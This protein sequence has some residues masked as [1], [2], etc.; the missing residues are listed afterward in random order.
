[1][2]TNRRTFLANGAAL[3][4][5]LSLPRRVLGARSPLERV[6]LGIVG[7]GWRGG[8]LLDTFKKIDGV[9]I[10]GLCDPD[11]KR[12]GAMA[13][14]LT[15]RPP[16]WKDMRGLFD[17]PDIDAVV[18]ANPN[19]WH[20]LSAIWALQ[21]GK[22]V[23]V[24]KPLGQ[25]QWEAQQLVNAVDR[26]GRICQV[27]T[28]QR[29]DPIQQEIRQLLHTDRA[30]GAIQSVTINRL[31]ERKPIGRRTSPMDVPPTIDFDLWTGPAQL[32]PI[33]R[34]ELQYDWH[35]DWNTG[36]GEMGNW[37]VHVLDDVRGTVLLDR[38]DLPEKVAATGGRYAWDDAGDTPNLQFVLFQAGGI[39]VQMAV[40]N[41]PKQ[42]G[43]AAVAGPPTG[44]TV[45]CE[46]GRLEGERG[47]AVAFDAQGKEVRR[48]AG[49]SGDVVHQK[50][51]IDA[52]RADSDKLLTAPVSVG[53][54]S[55]AWSNLANI[56]TRVS[57][58]LPPDETSPTE[59]SRHFDEPVLDAA[60]EYFGRVSASHLVGD[61][62]VA[63]KLAIALGIESGRFI[64]G[65]A[66]RANPMLKRE[67]RRKF[68]IPEILAA[69]STPS[70][71]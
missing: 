26:Y 51:F 61:Q 54:A 69:E 7:C 22:D 21:A 13:E 48:L 50:N 65:W 6:N 34:T 29:S 36:S 15:P 60:S 4:A 64:G 1:M 31:G 41:L 5:A 14:S 46:G 70:R 68:E 56:A 52:V 47:A 53:F 20:C 33:Y 43:A 59:L 30:L 18:I 9:V 37:G 2:R 12:L 27:G 23:Y 67:D 3:A 28:Q 66:P 44:Y 19:H 16:T 63:P 10:A 38:V 62:A 71:R 55:T 11:Q 25:T 40:C 57:N 58:S 17:S 42:P 32:K 39:P 49:N 35:W 8:Q 24:E 45:H